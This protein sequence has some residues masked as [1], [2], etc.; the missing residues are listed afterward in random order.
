MDIKI[1]PMDE[2]L[3]DKAESVVDIQDCKNAL[4]VGLKQY[5]GGSVQKRLDVNQGIID[6]IDI[7]LARRKGEEQHG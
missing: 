6:K 7:E 5:S 3:K 1:I 2:L 4:D